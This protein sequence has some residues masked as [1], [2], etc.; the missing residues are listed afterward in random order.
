MCERESVRERERKKEQKIDR[1][2]KTEKESRERTRNKETEKEKEKKRESERGSA[3]ARARARERE[4][5]VYMYI[6]VRRHELLAAAVREGDTP[7][8]A[9]SIHMNFEGSRE[10]FFNQHLPF[11]WWCK[12]ISRVCSRNVFQLAHAPKY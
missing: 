7:A 9:V 6:E 4:I 2:S 5:Y 10:N 11:R 3:C 12:V 1:E 8:A